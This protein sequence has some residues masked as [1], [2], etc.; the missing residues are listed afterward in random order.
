MGK[1]FCTFAILTVLLLLSACQKSPENEIVISRNNGA[2][3]ANVVQS[4]E[5][6]R[7]LEATESL[8]YSDTFQS[9]DGS[10]TFHISVDNTINTPNMPVVEVTPHFL[11]EEDAQNAAIALCGSSAEFYEAEPVLNERYSK[12]DVISQINRWSPYTSVE[13]IK[14]LFPNGREETWESDAQTLREAIA[15]LTSEYMENDAP[16]YAHSPCQWTF[17]KDSH[18]VYGED[19]EQLDTSKDNDQICAFAANENGTYQIVTVARRNKSDYKLNN[20]SYMATT[21]GVLDID[22]ALYRAENLRT[23]KPT[24]DQIRQAVDKAKTIME[25]MNLGTWKII[26]PHIGKYEAGN[27]TEYMIHMTAVPVF[28]GVTVIDCPQLSN[29]KTDAIF[30]S[31]YYLTKATFDFTPDG[32]LMKFNLYSPVDVKQVLNENVKTLTTDELFSRAKEQLSLSDVYAYKVDPSFTGEGNSCTVTIT[33][34]Q[35]GLARTKVPNTD[36]SYYYVPAA[37]FSGN[38]E[39]YSKDTGAIYNSSENA[40]LLVLNAVDGSVIPIRNE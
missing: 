12:S 24:E 32:S 3:D 36:E 29:L 19:A 26:S 27:Y 30:A 33:S 5:E 40:A 22:Y 16:N 39:H 28:E 37:M 31:N 20:I 10:V 34:V 15:Y 17:Y 18:Y 7:A 38:I 21:A 25:Q 6:S 8:R 13:N 1:K 9:T 11:T 2:F 4:A 23:D 14:E 35:Y